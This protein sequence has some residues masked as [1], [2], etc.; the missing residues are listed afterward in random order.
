V[1]VVIGVT[2]TLK[3]TGKRV[4]DTEIHLWTF[5]PDGKVVA[6]R[7]FLDTLQHAEAQTG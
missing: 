4:E 7:H 3:S 6:L 1:A 5:G 2:L